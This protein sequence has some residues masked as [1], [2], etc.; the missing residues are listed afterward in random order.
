MTDVKR[1]YGQMHKGFSGGGPIGDWLIHV[2][3]IVVCIAVVLKLAVWVGLVY[4]AH[5]FIV[6]FW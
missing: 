1:T 5:H 3:P 4:S 2:E 6:K